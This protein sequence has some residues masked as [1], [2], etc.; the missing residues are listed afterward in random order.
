MPLM[1]NHF[2]NNDRLNNCLVNDA[3]HVVPGQSG[4]HVELIQ[5][6]LVAIES[7]GIAPSER[8][9]KIY[10][11]T[12]ASA[13]LDYKKKRNLI[14]RSYQTT[15]D[16]IVGKMTIAALDQDMLAL[17]RRMAPGLVE[18]FYDPDHSTP[19]LDSIE[20]GGAKAKGPPNRG[21]SW[22]ISDIT[23]EVG[24]TKI[25]ALK[26]YSPGP[27][28]SVIVSTTDLNIAACVQVVRLRDSS[29]KRYINQNL[30]F[31]INDSTP[32][33]VGGSYLYQICAN[34][35]G[36]VE[37]RA[38][39]SNGAPYATPVRVNVTE[40]VRK[41]LSLGVP[42]V[43]LWHN[44]PLHA[45]NKTLNYPCGGDSTRR[46]YDPDRPGAN[47]P[48]YNMQCMTRLCWAL[49]KSN[50]SLA[51][52]RGFTACR[53]KQSG[54][55]DHFS[56]PYDFPYWGPAKGKG[57][58][59]TA[60]RPYALEPMPGIAAFWFVM[61]RTGIIL[62]KNYDKGWGKESLTGGHIDLW[63][64]HTMGNAVNSGKGVEA[65]SAFLRAQQVMFW[66]ID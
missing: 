64:G 49:R 58:S 18:S 38:V 39:R 15:A 41:V 29:K 61:N 65:L 27:P 44:H 21:P 51:G 52:M 4:S 2:R 54:H 55:Q 47:Y 48:L 12:T 30:S 45:H 5:N 16:N 26:K 31:V 60:W 66:P 11:N 3:A 13:V 35:P 50:V 23:L 24:K 63:N 10:G 59:W 14:N 6:A 1:S 42:F 28:P 7:S 17:E 37:L 22:P 8:A 34:R 62:F 25:V 56:D 53:I 40:K 33:E 36:T 46:G 19:I 9:A 43:T 20:I 32:V 57:F